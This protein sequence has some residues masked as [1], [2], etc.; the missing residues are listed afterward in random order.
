VSHGGVFLNNCATMHHLTE[1]RYPPARIAVI[2]TF[3]AGAILRLWFLIGGPP[4]FL[5]YTDTWGYVAEANGAYAQDQV[6]PYGFPFLLRAIHEITSRL[7]V[8]ILLQHGLG[9]ASAG[10]LYAAARRVTGSRWAALFPAA[11]ILFDGMQLVL[12]HS[13]LTE[14]LF[15][16]LLS[17]ACYAGQR[18][19]DGGLGWVAL[20]GAALG[21]AAVVKSTAFLLIPFFAVMLLGGRTTTWRARLAPPIV[22]AVGALALVG[23]YTAYLSGQP[24]ILKVSPAPSTGR[25]LYS[26]AATFADCRK[27]TPPSGTDNLCENTP[28]EDR[29]GTNHYLWGGDSPGWV[30]YGPPPRGDA[31]VEAF[32]LAAIEGQPGAFLSSIWKDAGNYVFPPLRQEWVSIGSKAIPIVVPQVRAYYGAKAATPDVQAE[33]KFL[34]SPG[35]CCSADG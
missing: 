27:F 12:E 20:A 5:G 34:S 35:R 23:A 7:D 6:H 31:P 24:G 19:F 9:L 29:Q 18:S 28:P 33:G 2:A 8:V 22:L 15:V 21:Y 4:V 3:A 17:V 14:T 25:V 30:L 16:F 1:R 10:L 26:R 13:L 32:S 11:V